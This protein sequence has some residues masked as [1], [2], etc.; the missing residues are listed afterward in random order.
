MIETQ[1]NPEVA[2]LLEIIQQK[3]LQI[4]KLQNQLEQLLRTV[5]GKKSERFAPTLPGQG[6]FAL[7]IPVLETPEVKTET[8]TYEREKP[9]GK[10]NHKGRLPLPDHL[11]RVD[12]DI[13]PKEDVTGLG[14]IGEEITEQLECEPGKLF[15]KRYPRCAGFA[16]LHLLPADF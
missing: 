11:Q 8:I 3:D 7:D 1:Q 16:I 15:V 6:S 5:Y 12:I 10:S 14:K 9:S 13:E 4:Q 2:A